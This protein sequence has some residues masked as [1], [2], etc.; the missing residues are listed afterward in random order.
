[1]SSNAQ[2]QT[3]HPPRPRP[4]DAD[5]SRWGLLT[6]FCVPTRYPVLL[7]AEFY[8]PLLQKQYRLGTNIFFLTWRHFAH[9]GGHSCGSG[10][11]R[12]GDG[13]PSFAAVIVLALLGRGARPRSIDASTRYPVASAKTLHLRVSKTSTPSRRGTGARSRPAALTRA[14]PYPTPPPRTPYPT[15]PCPSPPRPS[16]SQQHSPAYIPKGRPLG[17]NQPLKPHPH[18]PHSP[19]RPSLASAPHAHASSPG[20]SRLAPRLA[21][22]L[23]C[24]ARNERD[25]SNNRT[26][27]CA[28]PA[29][30]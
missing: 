15:P 23:P 11:R 25:K 7:L 2:S 28:T 3:P 10:L 4:P 6:L 19:A 18:P 16:Q 5:A 1:M 13:R 20:A 14:S 27:P 22:R 9:G 21:P 17:G 24:S 8:P 12:A 30:P 29:A 26:S